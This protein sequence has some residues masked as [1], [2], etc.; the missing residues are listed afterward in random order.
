MNGDDLVA[1]DPLQNLTEPMFYLLLSLTNERN[2]VEITN[3]ISELTNG[4]VEL[5]PGTLYALLAR[6]VDEEVIYISSEKGRSKYYSLTM[7]GK[8]L[9]REEIDRMNLLISDYERV[10]ASIGK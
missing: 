1:R 6:F 2:G 5:G 4:R 7:E 3:Y 8:K 9:L 10:L